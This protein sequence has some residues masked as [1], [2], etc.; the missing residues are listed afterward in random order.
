LTNQAQDLGQVSPI[1]TRIRGGG[2]FLRSV[3][4]IAV[5]AGV[6]LPH[7]A[8]WDDGQQSTCSREYV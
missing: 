3:P 8:P 4:P 7:V 5:R 2:T 6:V 1:V